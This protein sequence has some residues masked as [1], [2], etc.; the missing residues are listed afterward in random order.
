[1]N[2]LSLFGSVLL[3]L[4]PAAIAQ[5]VLEDGTPVKLR[6]ARTISSSDAQVGDTVDFE[7]L[8]EIKVGDVVIIPKGGLA[9]ATVTA[10]QS[11]RRMGRRGKLS[12]S[13]DFVRLLNGD[14]AALR[15]RKEV[16]GGSPSVAMGV[17]IGA[18]AVLFFPV[19]PL[20]LLM[21][22]S[23]ITVP[24]G[25]EITTY[26]NGT[27]PIEFANF[28]PSPNPYSSASQANAGLQPSTV[29]K[30]VSPPADCD[31]RPQDCWWP[32]Q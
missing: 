13:I 1:M 17:G 3:L 31:K 2:Y 8:E 27:L 14:K 12:M 11:K 30:P 20:F 18:S 32:K 26:I 28:R 15:G 4:S 21:H 23:D 7:V 29:V 5:N 10:A 19:A 6:I 24:K 22:G 25:T 16:E 9:W